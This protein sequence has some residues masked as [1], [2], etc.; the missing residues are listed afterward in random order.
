MKYLFSLVMSALLFMGISGCE[1]KKALVANPF[2]EEVWDT[3]YS[4]PPFDRMEIYHFKPAFEQG[5]ALHKAEIDSIVMSAEAP[6]F[7]SVILAYDNSGRMLSRVSGVFELL[8]SANTSDEM[9]ALS[10]EMMPLLSAHSDAILMN[11]SLFVK[12]KSVYDNRKQMK[13]TPEQNRLTELLYDR[14]VRSGALLPAEGKARLKEINERLSALSVSFGANLLA[15]TNNYA[16]DVPNARLNGVP[17]SVRDAAEQQ[18]KAMGRKGYIFTLHS[19]SML[20]LLTYADDRELRREIYNAYTSR[21]D[22]GNEYDNNA[23]IEEIV[24]L[25]CEKAKMLGYESFAHYVTSQQMAGTP[26]AVYELLEGIWTPALATAKSELERMEKLFKEDCGEDATFES[27][28]WWYYAEKVRQRDYHL[29]EATVRE[30]LSLENVKGGIFFLANRLYG[31]TFRPISVPLYHEECEAYEVID[32]N[33]VPLGVLY[34]DFHPRAG[35]RGGAWCGTYSPQYYQD[36]VRVPPVVTIVCN[37]TR[38]T[39]SQPALLSLDETETLFHEFGHALH[40]LFAEVKYRGLSE[41]EGDFVELPSQIIENWAFSPEMLKTYAVHYRTEEVMPDSM[42]EK[43]RRASK[44]NEGFATTELVAAA[45]SDMDIHLLKSVDSLDITAFQDSVLVG[46]R[47]LIPQIEPRYRYTYFNH[48]FNGGYSAGY[49]FYTWAEVLD[50][51]AFEAFEESGNLF[52]TDIAAA[53]RREILSQGGMRAGMDMYRAFRGKNPDK[54]A[55][56]RSRGFIEEPQEV[57]GDE[58]KEIEVGRVDTRELA[59]QRAE[60]SR[61]EREADK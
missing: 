36:G 7:E 31:I 49:Y 24:R 19:P 30:Y 6:S 60:K 42:I 10:A 1:G 26:A 46:K 53:F 13:L 47:G 58:P 15:E 20:P 37:F 56:L 51:D 22:S 23:I 11:D 44:F 54:E 2:F 9:E 29:E 41:V 14:F 59:R 57:E 38:P 61:R 3:P 32:S 17:Y 4:S 27:W 12:I 45:L 48:I 40:V 35:K 5:M 28:D 16:L 18:A 43:I 33:E 50:K 34:F 39:Q 55:L 21:G 8:N 52:N 25:R